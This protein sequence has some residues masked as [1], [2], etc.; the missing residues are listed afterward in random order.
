MSQLILNCQSDKSELTVGEKI[1]LNCA[2]QTA[3]DSFELSNNLKFKRSDLKEDYPPLTLLNLQK[4]NIGYELTV[5]S[6]RVGEFSA[7]DVVLL[8]DSQVIYL[9]GF[10]WKVG[11]ILSKENPQAQQPFPAFPAYEMSYPLWLFVGL[12]VFLFLIILLPIK[13]YKEFENRKISYKKLKDLETA[14]EPIDQFYRDIRKLE[15]SITTTSIKECSL[16]LTE[17]FKIFLSRRLQIPFF[18]WEIKRSLKELA[19]KNYRLHRDIS[20]QLGKLF[21]ELAS[22]RNNQKLDD[23]FQTIGRAQKISESIEDFLERD[24]K[25]NAKK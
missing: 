19:K 10:V 20:E 16:Q 1:K 2:S 13:I 25:R 24:E 17:D 6:Y 9:D 3:G 12:G 21:L 15:K 23:F 8:G 22:Y 11:S 7:K 5:T 4:N 14:F 18:D